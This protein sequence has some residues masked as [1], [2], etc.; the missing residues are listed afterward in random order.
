VAQVLRGLHHIHEN[1]LIHRD[2][3][4]ANVFITHDKTFKIGDFGLSREIQATGLPIAA[5]MAD[6]EAEVRGAPLGR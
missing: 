2:L 1:N 4:P 5:S 6:F 3:T